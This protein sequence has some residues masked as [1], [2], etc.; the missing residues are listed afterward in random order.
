MKEIKKLQNVL[1]KSNGA[2]NKNYIKIRLENTSNL[3]NSKPSNMN[4]RKLFILYM[5]TILQKR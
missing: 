1:I 3:V 5:H 2:F 4:N